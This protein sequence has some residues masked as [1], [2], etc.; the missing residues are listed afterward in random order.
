M[1]FSQVSYGIF[2]KEKIKIWIFFSSSTSS[3][4]LPPKQ[5]HPSSTQASAP[6]PSPSQNLPTISIAP[7]PEN[8]PSNGNRFSTTPLPVPPRTTA[9]PELKKLCDNTDYVAPRIKPEEGT[10]LGLLSTTSRFRSQVS[11]AALM[12]KAIRVETESMTRNARS[13]RFCEATQPTE[14]FAICVRNRKRNKASS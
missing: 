2:T 7:S 13:H 3:V 12:K 6:S 1:F 10:V 11:K 14:C 5:S 8:T 9:P 4:S